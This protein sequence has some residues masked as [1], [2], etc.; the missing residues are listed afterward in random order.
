MQQLRTLY[1]SLNL[2]DCENSC[3]HC[4]AGAIPWG[5]I[6]SSAEANDALSMISRAN[7]DKQYYDNLFIHIHKEPGNITKFNEISSLVKQYKATVLEYMPTN[8]RMISLQKLNIINKFY[9]IGVKGFSFTLCGIGN[10]HDEFV[11]RKGAYDDIISA[12]NICRANNI[13]FKMKALIHRKSLQEFSQLLNN[14]N[15]YI[16]VSAVQILIPE[17]VGNQIDNV[18]SMITK[19]DLNLLSKVIRLYI[20]KKLKTEKEWK[21]LIELQGI[22][23]IFKKNTEWRSILVTGGLD[24]YE[25]VYSPARYLGVLEDIEKTRDMLSQL[26]ENSNEVEKF[27]YCYLNEFIKYIEAPND[28]ILFDKSGI[29]NMWYGKWIERR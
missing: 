12:I 29:L 28:V 5:K 21:S 18:D 10:V 23:H 25:T 9:S 24:C 20:T 3:K 4:Y 6:L 19:D 17:Y 13:P 22:D 26:I 14:C 1:V 8:G 15:Q 27:S 11:R 2:A 16:P 7:Q